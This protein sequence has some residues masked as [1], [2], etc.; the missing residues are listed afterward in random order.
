MRKTLSVAIITKNE[1]ANLGRTLASV[2]GA[3]EVVVVDSG[4][5]DDTEPIARQAGAKFV[6]EEWKGYASQKN[7]AIA[8]CTSDWILSLDADEEISPDLALEIRAIL[9]RDAAPSVFLLPR[10]NHFLGRWIKHGGFYPDPKLR[11]FPR[12]TCLFDE[13]AV[14]ETMRQVR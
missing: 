13:R 2:N 11:L 8:R 1:G 14:H 9:E 6:S 12:G 5:A 10:R 3:D 4:S 7:S